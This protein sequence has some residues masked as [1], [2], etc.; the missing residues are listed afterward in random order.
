MEPVRAPYLFLIG[1]KAAPL[2]TGAAF[3]PNKPENNVPC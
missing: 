1:I 2:C 3:M